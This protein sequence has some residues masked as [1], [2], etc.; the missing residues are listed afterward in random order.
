MPVATGDK[1]AAIVLGD[2][3]RVNLPA[4]VQ[5]TNEISLEPGMVIP[6][7]QHWTNWI[8]QGATSPRF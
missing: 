8:G 3:V 4:P 7:D 5:V 2:V 6:L 1:F